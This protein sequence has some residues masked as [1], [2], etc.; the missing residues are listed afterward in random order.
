MKNKY[1]AKRYWN[2]QAT[3]MSTS[4]N[5]LNQY[6]DIINFTLG[7]PDINTNDEIIKLSF[8]DALNGHTH[9][10][11]ST[12]S[13]ELRKAI[14]EFY[15]D[16]YDYNVETNEIMVTTSGCHAM[17]LTLETILDDGDEVI[18]PSPYFTPYPDQVKLA[19]GIPVFLETLEEEDFQIDTQRLESLITNRTKAIIINTPNNPTGACLSTDKLKKI[20]ELADKHDLLIISDDIYTIYSYDEPFIPITILGDLRNRTITV[21]SFSKDYAMTGWRIGY[22]LAPKYMIDTMSNINEN[23]VFSA[24]SI[25]QRAAL[26]ALGLRK[27][28][29]PP[30]VEEF[31]KRTMYAYARLK[32]LKNVS[33]SKPKGTF[34]LFPS[35]K[36]T[37]LTSSEVADKIFE[38]A[39][40]QVIPGTAFGESGQ[41]YI[42]LACTLGVDKIEEAFDRISKM[43]I[44]R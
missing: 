16:K 27:E 10:T 34:Y 39:H 20:G 36:D 7:D 5:N 28:V 37:G 31:K 30:M 38:E 35:I 24:P 25:S 17:W 29:Q 14:S 22:I 43:S 33:I 12:G 3:E 44:F 41:G 21:S 19:R 32:E 26:H 40:V 9:Y 4:S 15:K 11:E 42:R 23:N 18:I 2:M 6:D 13:I 1:I 8:E